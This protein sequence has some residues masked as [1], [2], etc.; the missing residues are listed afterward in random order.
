MNWLGRGRSCWAPR[1]SSCELE[2]QI[3]TAST[4]AARRKG[5]A[6]DGDILTRRNL[7]R[8]LA[9]RWSEVGGCWKAAGWRRK[10]I[11]TVESEVYGLLGA[12][13]KPQ[14]QA[15]TKLIGNDTTKHNVSGTICQ[16]VNTHNPQNTPRFSAVHYFPVVSMWAF[17]NL[18]LG[19][20][21]P[22]DLMSRLRRRSA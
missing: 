15:E 4:A 13:I 18:S 8:R 7:G 5:V 16:Y 17:H 20:T 14:P 19:V 2:S 1:E 6:Y 3:A 22:T 12:R 11:L 9:L 10:R 21:D